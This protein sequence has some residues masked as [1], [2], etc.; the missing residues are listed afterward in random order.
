MASD[1]YLH[2]LNKVLK[3]VVI[4]SFGL[5]FEDQGPILTDL[6][7]QNQNQARLFAK[8]VIQ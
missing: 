3:F 1:M 8:D 4:Y 7:N 5:D 2:W 6:E